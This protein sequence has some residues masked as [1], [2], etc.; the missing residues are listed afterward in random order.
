VPERSQ[1]L[2]CPLAE[3][4]GK[5]SDFLSCFQNLCTY[6]FSQTAG[7]LLG[8]ADLLVKALG[9]ASE[10]EFQTNAFYL[11]NKRTNEQTNEQK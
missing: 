7:R 4:T 8:L 6:L 3:G 9:P 1:T 5:P 10:P 11:I 2:A